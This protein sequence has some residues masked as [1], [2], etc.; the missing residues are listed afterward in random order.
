MECCGC[1]EAAVSHNYIGID[2]YSWMKGLLYYR[3]MGEHQWQVCVEAEEDNH[4]LKRIK[5]SGVD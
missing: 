1:I 4:I 2:T 5:K 3:W